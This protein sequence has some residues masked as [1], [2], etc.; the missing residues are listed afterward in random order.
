MMVSVNI[1]NISNKTIR[2]GDYLKAFKTCSISNS[3]NHAYEFILDLV[4][5]SLVPGA[6]VNGSYHLRA[7][8]RHAHETD[9]NEMSHNLMHSPTRYHCA[10]NTMFESSTCSRHKYSIINILFCCNVFNQTFFSYE[11]FF[12]YIEIVAIIFLRRLS[13]HKKG[14]PHNSPSSLQC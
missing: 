2:E 3:E 8:I 11:S 5:L 10:D 12:I 7:D 14:V 6:T 1:T 9:T 4:S 13:A